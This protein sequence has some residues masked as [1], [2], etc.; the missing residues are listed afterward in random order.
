MSN[1]EDGSRSELRDRSVAREASL[2]DDHEPSLGGEKNKNSMQLDAPI[3]DDG[4][5]S[6][7]GGDMGDMGGGGGL[8][9][10]PVMAEVSTQPGQDSAAAPL[11]SER[12]GSMSD[13]DMGNDFGMPSP[14]GASSPGGSRPTSP[15]PETS[16]TPRRET[17]SMAAPPAPAQDQT[18]LLQNEE[19]SF[20]LA[21]VDASAMRGTIR[22]KRKRKLIVD[23]VKAIAG[24]EMKAQLS[25]TG[26]IVTT[27]DLA[28]PTKR[29]MHWKETGGVEK[30]F[31]L[32]G[33]TLNSRNIFKAY[34]NQLVSHPAENEFFG[35]LGDS[36][37]EN[38]AL[39]NVPGAFEADDPRTPLKGRPGRKRKEQLEQ[40]QQQQ[41][42]P[43][44]RSSRLAEQ[45]QKENVPP[46]SAE[47]SVFGPTTTP[48]NTSGDMENMGY[49]QSDP[50][51]SNMGYNEGAP[52]PGGPASMGAP[53]PYRDDDYYGP[54]S[55]ASNRANEDDQMQEGETIEEFEDRVLNK[56]AGHLNKILHSKFDEKSELGFKELA[57]SRRHLRKQ[58]AQKF[59]SLLVLQKVMAVNLEQEKS[60]GEIAVT[61]GQNFDT[62]VI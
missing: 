39:E 20:A 51:M 35:L 46:T 44:K 48:G 43:V 52:T 29:L 6:H 50:N 34:Q 36:E 11:G 56:R 12:R 41:A 23:E 9:D 5:G 37:Q 30:L 26:D 55:V 15:Q 21:P 22:T 13:D 45:H 18:T 57:P 24:E 33:H 28:P 54:N 59:Y 17:R 27:L 16:G 10:E 60:Y 31:A 2:F 8:F 53:T 47:D 4:F 19:E 40:E 58:A 38:I 62:A 61:K 42:T 32:P 25:D 7:I 1:M 49:N 14:G 3:M